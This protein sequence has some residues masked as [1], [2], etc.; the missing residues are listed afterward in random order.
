MTKARLVL[1][2]ESPEGVPDSGAEKE[3]KKKMRQ[4][5]HSEAEIH[6]CQIAVNEEVIFGAGCP[7][8]KEVGHANSLVKKELA[9]RRAEHTKQMLHFPHEHLLSCSLLR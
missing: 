1:A 3:A 5:K 6:R 7:T 9:L 2:H 8:E 4:L